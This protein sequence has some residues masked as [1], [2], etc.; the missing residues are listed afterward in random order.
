MLME[1][2]RKEVVEYGKKMSSSRLTNGTSGNLSVYNK[3]LGYMAISPSGIGYF[4]TTIEDIVITDLE[5]NVIDGTCKP[6]SEF[7][8]H[9]TMYKKHPEIGAVVHAHSMYCTTFACLKKPIQAIH[10]L[11]A[12]AEEAEVPCVE[13][14]T[15]GSSE[16]AEKVFHTEAKGLAMLLANHGMVAYGPSMAKA[17]NVA[18]NVEWC[19]EIQWRAQ[20]IGVPAVLDSSEI[21]HVIHKFKNYGQSSSGKS[22]Y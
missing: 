10:Y 1:K 14:A 18:E 5:G 3:D 2:E 16:L 8:L 22:G 13:Y 20:C 15:Y 17:F 21:D 4:E 6:S 12:G 9:A 7:D 19:A 11:I